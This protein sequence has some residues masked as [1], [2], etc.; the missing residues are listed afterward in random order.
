MAV[1]NSKFSDFEIK[2]ISV[3]EFVFE[4]LSE[5]P[6]R[7]VVIDGV[8]GEKTTAGTLINDIKKLAGGLV[9]RNLGIGHTIAIMS[10]NVPEYFT[11]FHAVAWAGG[12]VTTINPNYTA[13]EAR[14]QLKDAKVE[15][16][17]IHPDFLK[18]AQEAVK[19][20]GVEQ[21][22]T[23]GETGETTPLSQIMGEPLDD[24]VPV[25]LN[26]HVV[27]LPYSSGTTGLP[28]GVMLTHRNLVAN[29][30]QVNSVMAL[31][32]GKDNTNAT[33]AFLPFFHIYGLLIF[34]NLY[35]ASGG[36]VITL[37]RFD[38]EFFLRLAQD[39]KSINLWIV[40]PVALALARHPAVDDYD[41]SSVEMIFSGA[42]PLGDELSH[43]VGERL[44]CIAVQGY[45]MTE[46]SPVCHLMPPSEPR[47]GSVGLTIA[48]T[49]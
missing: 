8:T 19:G 24:Q 47:A 10:P 20:T 32:Q 3:T 9:E 46:L 45:G 30:G 44:N 15:I 40:P 41:L 39:H 43:M 6:D 17:I 21:I 29:L 4:G 18:T 49:S 31:Q 7:V 28:K 5:S 34:L 11:I 1:I 16:L 33:P 14:H 27:V 37:P 48:G 38:L 2:N 12:T 13:P 26:N 35:P 36:T 23:I 25:D 42:A 22:V